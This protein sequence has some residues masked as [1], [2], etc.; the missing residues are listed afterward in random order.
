VK[1]KRNAV[2]GVG[3]GVGNEKGITLMSRGCRRGMKKKG[4]RIVEQRCKYRQLHC[5]EIV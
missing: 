1:G 4:Q 2:E 3:V 5:V